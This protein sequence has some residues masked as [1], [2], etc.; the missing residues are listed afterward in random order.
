ME[1]REELRKKMLSK[2]K[3]GVA[4]AFTG[5]DVHIIKAVNLL[6]DLDESFNILA[7]QCREWYGIHF[8]ELN[9]LVRDHESFLKLVSLGERKEFKKSIIL[10]AYQNEEA[11]AKIEAKAPSS[12]GGEIEKKDL[13]QIQMLAENALSIRQE[14]EKLADYIA[15][16][17][18]SLAP[19]F[20]ELAEPLLAAKM[21]A[22]AS[23]LRRLAFMPSST[24]Q[25]LGA[26]KA[27]FE[28][29][30]HGS[31]PPKYG[32]LYSNPIIKK[33]KPW[34]KGKLSRTLAGKLS[35][36]LKEDFFGK[37]RLFPELK[38]GIERKAKELEKK[39]R[40]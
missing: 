5:K 38:S 2:A 39:G 9:S 22:K 30:K 40:K 7:E 21:L 6:E 35:I 14:R 29:L 13:E 11:A 28:H 26:E 20:A 17:M 19:N 16:E 33:A 12:M 34:N 25:V 24:L 1:K 37:K 15:S 32:I 23:S 8:P 31:K 27:L 3:K 10:K 36:A 4:E 18:K